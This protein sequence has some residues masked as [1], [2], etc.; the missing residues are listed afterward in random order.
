[1][2]SGYT[3]ARVNPAFFTGDEVRYKGQ[4]YIVDE[5]DDE[6][7][8]VRI[9]PKHGG[10]GGKRDKYVQPQQ[11]ALVKADVHAPPAASRKQTRTVIVFDERGHSRQIGRAE[12]KPEAAARELRPGAFCY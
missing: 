8:L 3:V 4:R 5:P 1:M 9:Y 12:S 7:G 2:G 6:R 10:S 11:I